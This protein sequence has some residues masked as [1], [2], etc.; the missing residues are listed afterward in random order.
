MGL[1]E[2]IVLGVALSADAFAV[3]ISNCFVY[4]SE[5][6]R[7]L[8]LMP[9]M[10][11]LFQ[12]L[13]P[14]AG[15]FVGGF[16][17]EVIEKYSGIVTLI[18]LGFIGGNM[19]REG[20]MALMGIGEDAAVPAVGGPAAKQLTFGEVFV[21]AIA[22]AIDAFA[23]GVSLRAQ[24]VD[25]VLSASIIGLTTFGCCCV[26]LVIGRR[27]GHLLGDYAEVVGGLVLVGIG[28]KAFIGL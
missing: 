9:I 10:F 11:G 25:I 26:A 20:A 12:M 6:K 27:L 3:T 14:I 7:K 16:A 23:V 1:A 28:I 2:L 5:R 8:M 15:Y 21:Q 17:A 24:S 13:M 18:I 4:A 22:T 19:V